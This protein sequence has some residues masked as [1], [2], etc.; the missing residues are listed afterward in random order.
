MCEHGPASGEN[1]SHLCGL[2]I[3]GYFGLG[4]KGGLCSNPDT[5]W[6]VVTSYVCMQPERPASEFEPGSKQQCV[7]MLVAGIVLS[8]TRPAC[9]GTKT[10]CTVHSCAC[11]GAR[12]RLEG[13]PGIPLSLP[14]SPSLSLSLSLSIYIYI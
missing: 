6:G 13:P 11:Q 9:P 8:I 1:I 4:H 3:L 2:R 12:A 14:L 7:V 10:P 5:C